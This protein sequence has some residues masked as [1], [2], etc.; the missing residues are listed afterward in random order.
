MSSAQL[1]G[2]INLSSNV[3]L[4]QTTF[5]VGR[6][7]VSFFNLSLPPPNIAS[8]RASLLPFYTNF[9]TPYTDPTF[10]VITPNIKAALTPGFQ[11]AISISFA[12][13]L[14]TMGQFN[15]NLLTNGSFSPQQFGLQNVI[16]GPPS[17]IQVPAAGLG[18]ATAIA[19]SGNTISPIIPSY[20][21]PHLVCGVT[22]SQAGALNIQRYVDVAGTVAQ[23]AALTAALTGATPAVLD[24][25]D[26][27]GFGSFTVQITNTGTVTA[28]VSGLAL[29]LLA[30]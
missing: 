27:K 24:N 25:A 30:R 22:S 3:L 11:A 15:P 29:L 23:G 7:T 17:G 1:L 19:A 4:T 9:N 26:G 20:Y 8:A 28:T 21:Y 16:Q 6:G 13:P 12:K 18:L 2:N 5:G 10:F 14:I